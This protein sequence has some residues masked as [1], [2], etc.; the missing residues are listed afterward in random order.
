MALGAYELLD[1]VNADA[2]YHA[3]MIH[4]TLGDF[5]GAGAR[6]YHPGRRAGHCSP[7]SSGG[8]R[9]PE[10]RHALL[11]RSYRELPRPLRP[12]DQ[13]GPH[14]VPGAPARAGRL[15]NPGQGEP[16][17]VTMTRTIH[18]G[19]SP[20]SDD[21]FMFYALAENKLDTGDL[22]YVHEL[23]DIESLN[24]RALAGSSRSR[25]C[26]STPTPTWRTATP[27]WPAAPPWA[28]GTAPAWCP[29]ARGRPIPVG[30][31]GTPRGGPGLRTTAYL[32][33]TLYQPDIEASR[34]AVRPDR[35][36]GQAGEA[37]WAS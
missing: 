18:V 9:G 35:R 27:C 7:T 13:G 14:R 11:N 20:D 2:R 22:R 26:R 4:L 28:T 5:P 21:A 10:E 15:Q 23:S 33:L 29:P 6:G 37:T 12:R 8:N 30:A 1:T 34:H 24:R 17:T 36:R 19:H 3:A 32:A 25:R 31:A 16:A